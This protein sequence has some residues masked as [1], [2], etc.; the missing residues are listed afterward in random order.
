MHKIVILILEI[1]TDGVRTNKIRVFA[2]HANT[3]KM[4]QFK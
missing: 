4:Y 3:L 1:H 2:Y